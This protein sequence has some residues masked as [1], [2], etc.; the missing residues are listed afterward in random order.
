MNNNLRAINPLIYHAEVP[1]ALYRDDSPPADGEKRK[2]YRG[3][4]LREDSRSNKKAN[5]KVE[6]HDLLRNQ[7]TNVICKVNPSLR[8]RDMASF[9]NIHIAA[10][11]KDETVCTLDMF[12]QCSI[13]YCKKTHC[14]A[15]DEEVKHMVNMLDK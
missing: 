9:Y 10:L 2:F 8:F 15:M 7:F 12:Q 1:H 3:Y 5:P 6:I 14:K 11:S 4:R 13:S